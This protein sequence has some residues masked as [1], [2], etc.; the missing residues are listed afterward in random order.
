M[1]D[2]KNL[3]TISSRRRPARDI[4]ALAQAKV[5]RVKKKPSKAHGTAKDVSVIARRKAA[6]AKH[7]IAAKKVARKEHL[8]ATRAYWRGDSDEHP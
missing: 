6:K 2:W 4:D 7:E 8:A 3:P 5:R 1:I